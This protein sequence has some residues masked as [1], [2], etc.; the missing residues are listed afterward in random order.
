MSF[1]LNP[2]WAGVADLIIWVLKH[3]YNGWGFIC[4]DLKVGAIDLFFNEL[5]VFDSPEFQLGEKKYPFKFWALAP[6]FSILQ[7]PDGRDEGEILG[8]F[9]NQQQPLIRRTPRFQTLK[10]P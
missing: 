9:P 3:Q 10:T 7:Q 4:P 1:R 8:I 5:I 2:A 6:N